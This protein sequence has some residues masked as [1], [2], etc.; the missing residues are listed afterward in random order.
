MRQ[1]TALRHLA[2]ARAVAPALVIALVAF[3]AWYAMLGA[4][5][6]RWH[7]RGVEASSRT[8]FRDLVTILA[9]AECAAA[10]YDVLV[11]NPCDPDGTPMN[12]PRLWVALID[13]SGAQSTSVRSL[14]IALAVVFFLS[15]VALMRVRSA[16]G[17]VVWALAL[18]SPAVTLAVERSNNDLVVFVLVVAA[19]WLL[20]R[21]RPAAAAPFLLFAG[22]LKLFPALAM[23]VLFLRRDRT[24]RILAGLC[25]VLFAALVLLTFGDLEA[26]ARAT[27]HTGGLSYGGEVTAAQFLKLAGLVGNQPLLLT[28]DL[29][30]AALACSVTLPLLGVSLGLL[31]RRRSVGLAP[32][33]TL[34]MPFLAGTLI[35][36]GTFA[37]GSNWDYRLTFLLL[38]LPGSFAAA[39]GAWGQ[40]WV[41][42]LGALACGCLLVALWAG[43]SFPR[44][45]PWLLRVVLSRLDAAATPLL[46]VLLVALATAAMRIAKTPDT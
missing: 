22:T 5:A 41:A 18:L 32:D 19:T 20:P 30:R 1:P 37:L 29:R 25:L 26:I 34:A 17:A 21:E 10:G 42:R 11:Q 13:G 33:P 9:G 38:A 4:P 43:G 24:L 16:G 46:V 23:P 35:F 28:P 15:T 31:A 45:W 7:E 12:Y 39:G 3:A 14:G 27:P 36:V 8:H 40:G 2:S 44:S 6:R